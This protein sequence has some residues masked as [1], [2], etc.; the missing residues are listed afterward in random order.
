MSHRPYETW[1]PLIVASEKPRWVWWRDFALTL[2]MWL[3][4]AIMLGTEFELW[5]GRY[6]E[7]LGLGH[8]D[9]NAHWTLFFER[10]R[11]YVYLII[12]LLAF[13]AAAAVAT[14]HRRRRTLLLAPPP[15]LPVAQQARRAGMD[16]ADL[17]VARKLANAVVHTAPDGGQRVEPRQA[18]P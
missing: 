5:F 2:A 9:T 18:A 10:L 11:P 15:P 4:F 1:P 8:F 16:E 6:L 17:L 12:S 14:N 3:M 7:R 13:L